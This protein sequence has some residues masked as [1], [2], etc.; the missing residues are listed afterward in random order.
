MIEVL[1]ENDNIPRFK[2]SFFSFEMSENT[3][4]GTSITK[5]RAFDDDSGVN[6]EVSYIMET[7]TQNFRVDKETGDVYVTSPL[8]RE[9]QDFYHLKAVDREFSLVMKESCRGDGSPM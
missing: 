9:S 4:N 6:G 1:D 8:D 5:L 3:E 2:K 7:D